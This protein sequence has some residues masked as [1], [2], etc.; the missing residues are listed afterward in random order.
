MQ[1]PEQKPVK[2]MIEVLVNYCK[3]VELMMNIWPDS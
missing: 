3:A 1:R 2:W